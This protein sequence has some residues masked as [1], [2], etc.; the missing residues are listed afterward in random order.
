M[1]IKGSARYILGCLNGLHIRFPTKL[2]VYRAVVLSS[3]IYVGET[4]TPYKRRVKKLEVFHM[5]SLQS[6]LLHI[7]WKDKVTNLQSLG[8]LSDHQLRTGHVILMD[9]PGSL[10]SFSLASSLKAIIDSR[11]TRVKAVIDSRDTCASSS[12]TASRPT[13]NQTTLREQQGTE[14]NGKPSAGLPARP[15]RKTVANACTMPW[16]DDLDSSILGASRKGLPVPDM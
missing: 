11:D 16:T 12:K 14:T 7:L 4:W 5:R 13:S 15:L 9:R 2:L 1:L 3:L 6:I 8:E 10:D